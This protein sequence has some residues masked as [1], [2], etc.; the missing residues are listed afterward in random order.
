MLCALFLFFLFSRA[1]V[2]VYRYGRGR[3]PITRS[4]RLTCGAEQVQEK[5]P[6]VALFHPNHLLSDVLWGGAHS[7]H[8]QKDVVIQEIPGQN[9]QRGKQELQV[10]FHSEIG[11][12]QVARGTEVHGA[13]TA[14]TPVFLWERWRWTSWSAGCL[15]EAWCPAQRCAVSEA[16]S[17]YP[18]CDPLHPGQGT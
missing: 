11:S 3:R 2:C 12:M 17:P 4:N 1:G 15:S 13:F 16:Q 18:A 14:H 5:R 10:L 7:S 6:L 8:C 9:L